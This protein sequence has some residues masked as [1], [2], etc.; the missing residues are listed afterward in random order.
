MTRP[1]LLGVE[2]IMSSGVGTKATR[3]ESWVARLAGAD[4]GR[5]ELELV[6]DDGRAQLAESGSCRV[7]FAGL[8]QNRAE[9]VESLGEAGAGAETEAELVAAGYVR[10]GERFLQK[11]RGI[12]GIVL[13]DRARG[14][15]VAI[16]DQVG[17]HPL[18]W[19][20]DG[21]SV[22]LSDSVKA[23]VAQPDVSP[24][25]NLAALV[26][27]LRRRWPF[28][29][30]TYFEAVRR[31]PPGH[32]LRLGPAGRELLRYWDP[33]PPGA[34]IEWVAPDEVNR[35]GDVLYTAL[36]R[37]LTS[38]PIAVF[39]S[40]GLDSVTIAALASAAASEQGLAKPLALSL[41]FPRPDVSEVEIQRGV[42][43]GLGLPQ[44]MLEWEEAVGPDGLILAALELGAHVSAPLANF[45]APAYD[46]LAQQG[47]ARGCQAILTGAGGDEWLGVSPHYAADLLKTAN[48]VG[49][50]RLYQAQ[51]RSYQLSSFLFT[52]N[53]LWRFGAR[54]L[55]AGTAKRALRGAAP[56]VELARRLRRA[57]ARVPDWLAPDPELHAGI[58]ERERRAYADLVASE[59]WVTGRL[60][61]R[62]PRNY[63][64]EGRTALTQTLMAMEHEETFE[65]ARRLELRLLHPFWD[66][67]VVEF[68]YRTPPEL[69]NRG[70]RSK[71]VVRETLAR[72]FPELGFERQRKV[73]ATDFSRSLLLEEGGRAWRAYGGTPALA[74]AGIVDGNEANRAVEAALRKPQGRDYD[75]IWDLLACETWLRAQM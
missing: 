11:L 64:L 33:V 3:S 57:S 59:E 8:L 29:E 66:V 7:V 70:G 61:W 19:A 49:L 18:F 73:V 5:L 35:F 68:L 38:G 52:R 65:Q 48:V 21:E 26:D 55:L 41:A 37:S 58:V 22:V 14:D 4:T 39:L 36:Q 46:R 63:I 45:W 16:R 27:H 43:I 31:V 54:P 75:R 72:R 60:P 71:G 74:E 44:V 56:R 25:V 69:L 30:E 42:A 24:T 6:A 50:Y 17:Q 32:A 2:R 40:G 9:L 53:I 13:T 67:D 23:L 12:F 34:P 47:K 51:R 28:A 10:D 1:R 15:A 20:D 62:Y